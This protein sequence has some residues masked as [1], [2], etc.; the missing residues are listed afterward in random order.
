MLQWKTDSQTIVERISRSSHTAKILLKTSDDPILLPLWLEHYLSF[1]EPSQIVIAD[2]KST[3]HEVLDIYE[4]IES[5]VSIFSYDDDIDRGFHNNIH[6][7]AV[8]PALYE[9]FRES[10]EYLFVVDTDEL[11]YLFDID[12]WTAD[13]STFQNYLGCWS[14][15]GM[16]ST[17]LH[18]VR[19][20]TDTCYIGH[21]PKHLAWE[22]RWGKPLIPSA[23]RHAGVRIHNI[24]FPED[25]FDPNPDGALFLLHL[26]DYSREQRLRINK[27]KLVTRGAASADD[28]FESIVSRDYSR[29]GDPTIERLVAETVRLLEEE[30]SP[31]DTSSLE[32]GF[33]RLCDDG[34]IEYG[35]AATRQIM[36]SYRAHFSSHLRAAFEAP[37]SKMANQDHQKND[38][39]A[40]AD[41]ENAAFS[42]SDDALS[43]KESDR[44]IASNVD[45]GA[46]SLRPH[47]TDSEIELFTQHLH[48]ARRL[49]EFGC[50]GSTV[51]AGAEGASGIVSV[52]S[53]RAWLD[54]VAAA[55]E[56]RKTSF[57]PV[58]VDIGPIGAWGVPSDHSHALKWP[59]Y[60]T[61][62]WAHVAQEPD[63]VFI[64]GRFRIACTLY[65]L[66]KCG[67]RA[68]YLIH[69]FWNR[70]HYHCVLEF[71]DCIDRV[72]TLGVFVAKETIDWRRLALVLQAHAMDFQ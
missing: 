43:R 16:A 21:D 26:R 50:G 11:L 59:D 54:K 45:E 44:G 49:L 64:D 60:Y 27:K 62:V 35:D 31:P 29:S 36:I 66:L 56:L 22:L 1:L 23:F 48:G 32:S 38:T 53:D 13:R 18:T 67:G 19:G 40:S 8:F 6:D 68:K 42:A 28:D 63:V 41:R 33:L 5:G 25:S 55:P 72:D 39:A 57:Q 30:W 58:H 7:R 47:M 10:C 17:W 52:D 20:S 61:A 46:S 70:D 65:S 71:L 2:N 15:K 34:R 9:A 12:S 24:Q 4:N 14:G 69:D 3:D 51:L 37:E